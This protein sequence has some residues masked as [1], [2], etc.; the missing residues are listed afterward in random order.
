MKQVFI[1]LLIATGLSFFS[2]CEKV[3]GE[4]P[5]ASET[6]NV[7]GFKGV[8][9]TISGKVNYTIDPVY[10]VE[11]LA[12]RN[13]LEVLETYIVGDELVIKFKDG[14]RV[15]DYED[16]TVNIRAPFAELVNLSG[17]ADVFVTGNLVSPNLNLKLS[18]SGNMYVQ[19]ATVA[20]KL[21]VA[22]SGSGN[23][24]VQQGSAVNESLRISGSGK[25]DLS[26][27][28][29]QKAVA[30]ISGSGDMRIKVSQNLEASISGSGSVYYIGNPLVSTHIS[31][32][33]TVRPL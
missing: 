15:K 23:I 16:I 30:E 19:Q 13:I 31:G 14:V 21:G 3:I 6:R 24:N 32:S 5:L 26:P 28:A 8:S 2:S 1:I 20:D 25:I 10:K 9:V 17:A 29:A 12:Q 7:Q 22:I 33:G 18:G 27:V 11:V 4:G